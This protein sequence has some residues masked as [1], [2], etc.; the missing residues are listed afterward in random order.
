MDD[1]QN[2][3][4]VAALRQSF[5][6]R[7]ASYDN[8]VPA[9]ADELPA[10]T[11][12][13]ESVTTSQSRRRREVSTANQFTEPTVPAQFKL[14][15]DLVQSLKLHSINTGESMSEI[16]LRCLTSTDVIEKA[17]ISTRKAS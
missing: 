1:L 15:A 14:P 13:A 4:P 6:A 12:P 11:A 2:R 7:S 8:R 3:S 10:D 17:W 16:V 5:T 9:P